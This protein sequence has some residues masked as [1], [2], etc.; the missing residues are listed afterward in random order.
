MSAATQELGRTIANWFTT[1]PA[2]ALPAVRG[3]LASVSNAFTGI[4]SL[5]E[6]GTP[7]DEPSTDREETV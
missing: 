3:A 6:P 2:T 5:V 1:R 7:H 4:S